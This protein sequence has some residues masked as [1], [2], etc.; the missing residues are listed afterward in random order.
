M[1]CE[2]VEIF[3]NGKIQHLPIYLTF[4]VVLFFLW[5]KS[6]KKEAKLFPAETTDRCIYIYIVAGHIS[7]VVCKLYPE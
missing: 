6:R 5:A 3:R 2:P 4:I 1:V 7:V